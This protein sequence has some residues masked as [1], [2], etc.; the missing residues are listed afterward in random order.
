MGLFPDLD[1]IRA[2]FFNVCFGPGN[3]I[4]AS[5]SHVLPTSFVIRVFDISSENCLQDFLIVKFACLRKGVL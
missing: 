2:D 3:R 1:P 5:T 4:V